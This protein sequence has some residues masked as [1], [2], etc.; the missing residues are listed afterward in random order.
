MPAWLGYPSQAAYA[1]G[2][3]GITGTRF[4]IAAIAAQLVLSIIFALGSLVVVFVLKRWLR[5]DWA[6]AGILTLFFAT[7]MVLNEAPLVITFTLPVIIPSL[8]V[9]VPLRLGLLT[10][11]TNLFIFVLCNNSPMTLD[12]TA[13]YF[14]TGLA[15]A[16]IVV[17]LSVFGFRISQGSRRL[18]HPITRPDNP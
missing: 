7:S 1:T 4:F 6:L 5:H 8:L 2:A 10:S 18:L 13:W 9:F 14:G 17:G 16:L 12:T 11:A 3:S 15:A